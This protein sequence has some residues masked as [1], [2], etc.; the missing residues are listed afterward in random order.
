MK[1]TIDGKKV[2]P[3]TEIIFDLE[4]KDKKIQGISIIIRH[5]NLQILP[6]TKE[7]AAIS[8]TAEDGSTLAIG[9]RD[10]ELSEMKTFNVIHHTIPW[11][12]PGF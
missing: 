11:T 7:H 6:T 8:V 12:P 9:Q 2:Q 10:Y 5:G 3:F 1:I 4:G